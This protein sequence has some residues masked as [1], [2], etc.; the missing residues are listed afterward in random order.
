MLQNAYTN[1]ISLCKSIQVLSINNLLLSIV[2][3]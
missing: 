1:N 2:Q 3:F